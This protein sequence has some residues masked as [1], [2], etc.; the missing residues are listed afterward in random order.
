[1]LN[2]TRIDAINA[3][4]GVSAHQDPRSKAFKH[5]LTEFGNTQRMI[6][7][8]GGNF[9]YNGAQGF[10]VYNGKRWEREADIQVQLMAQETI[11]HMFVEAS[12][13]LAYAATLPTD[14]ARKA[15]ASQAEALS[16]WARFSSKFKMV[17]AMVS[18]VKS[19]PEVHIEPEV[20][21]THLYLFNFQNGTVDV[22]TGVM[23]K[24]TKQDFLTQ[25]CPYAY[26]PQ[27]DCPVFKAFFRDAMCGD[28][29]LMRF[30]K[31]FLGLSTTG[32]VSEH[33]W[34]MMLGVGENGK[35]TLMEAVSGAMG[36]DYAGTM[37]DRTISQT[38]SPSD[39]NAPSPEVADLK[40][41]RLITVSETEEGARIKTEF[42]KRMSGGDQE[43]ARYLHRNPFTFHYTN[44]LFLYTNHNPIVRESSHGFW[45][46]V[47][48]VPFNYQVP[49]EKKDL[50]LPNKLH[51]EAE[52]ILAWLVEGAKL[53][54]SEGLGMPDVVREAT[55]NYRAEQDILGL[56]VKEYCD[57]GA[58]LIIRSK[59]FFQ[60]F[61]GWLEDEMGMKKVT[62][63]TLKRMMEDH[64]YAPDKDREGR[65][66]HGLARKK[67]ETTTDKK[68]CQV[69]DTAHI[70][71]GNH[72]DDS[73]DLTLEGIEGL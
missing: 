60:L 35:T 53:W 63:P 9:K 59:E 23:H 4:H 24:H 30:M 16:G 67:G 2:I 40:G 61:N 72:T 21:D 19:A 47:R 38:N 37:S 14:E 49:P 54:A 66:F 65:F 62:M 6:D 34:C 11:K 69:P 22:R 44:K 28:K 39:G 42:I 29:D 57:E 41:K 10:L 13:I 43:K 5:D 25:I 20:F 68:D 17:T 26:N 32:D 1:M 31:K 12:A 51:A 15:C 36:P 33:A 71:N 58:D 27:A 8:H 73:L 56:Y 50:D 55:D 45:R 48:R 70:A 46:R 18:L 3:D 52:G 64:K 7:R